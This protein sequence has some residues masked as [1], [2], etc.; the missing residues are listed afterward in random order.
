[1]A[2]SRS[3]PQLSHSILAGIL[4]AI[5]SGSNLVS[6]SPPNSL[7]FGADENPPNISESVDMR[8]ADI[9]G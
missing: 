9:Q 2:K 8:K 5:K 7:V 6:E 4:A 1:M 3:P